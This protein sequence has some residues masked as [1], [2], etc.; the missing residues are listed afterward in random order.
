[1]QEEATRR[2]EVHRRVVEEQIQ[3]RI[4]GYGPIGDQL[5]SERGSNTVQEGSN[6]VQEGVT[7]GSRGVKY[8]PRGRGPR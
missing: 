7:Y 4:L 6:T 2:Q 1:M 5:R 8:G 3:V